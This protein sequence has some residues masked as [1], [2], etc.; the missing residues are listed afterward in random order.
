MWVRV[1]GHARKPKI[2]LLFPSPKGVKCGKILNMDTQRSIKTAVCSF[3]GCTD[4]VGA[5]ELCMGHYMQRQ[6]GLELRPIA[7][8][9]NRKDPWT[10]CSVPQC[11]FVRTN[12]TLCNS[13]TQIARRFCLTHDELTDLLTDATC[14]IC[15]K[16]GLLGLDH[17]HACCPGSKQT[18]GKCFRG[19]LCNRCNGLLGFA[20]DDPVLLRKMADY[21]ER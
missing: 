8:R 14:A 12:G 16:T 7:R 4:P 6:R 19:L 13:H 11:E 10:P 20:S 21:L 5:K 15:H 1:K 18:C 2:F 9:A 17:D 3:E